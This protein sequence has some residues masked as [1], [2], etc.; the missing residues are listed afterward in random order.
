MKIGIIAF[1]LA[2]AGNRV[3]RRP[4]E[5]QS[6]AKRLLAWADRTSQSRLLVK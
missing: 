3:A 2:E 1:G 4:A 5:I 6:A